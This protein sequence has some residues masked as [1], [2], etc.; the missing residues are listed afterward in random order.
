MAITRLNSTAEVTISSIHCE[1]PSCDGI[2]YLRNPIGLPDTRT[3]G[4]QPGGTTLTGFRLWET[5]TFKMVLWCDDR[6]H[7]DYVAVDAFM[8]GNGEYVVVVVVFVIII[9]T[10]K[11]IICSYISRTES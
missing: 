10:I 4:C 11:E 3:V 5:Y 6:P 1:H 8:G 9:I 2:V 7:R